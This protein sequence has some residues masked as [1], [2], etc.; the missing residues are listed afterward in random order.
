MLVGQ[1]NREEVTTHLY[2]IIAII[3]N[4]VTHLDLVRGHKLEVFNLKDHFATLTAVV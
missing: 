2:R 1:M 3:D 4:E